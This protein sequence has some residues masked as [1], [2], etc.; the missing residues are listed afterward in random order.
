M[1]W[2][3][4]PP[5]VFCQRANHFLNVDPTEFNTRPDVPEPHS[6]MRQG[7]DSKAL[8][9]QLR[10]SRFLPSLNID[11]IHSSLIMRIGLVVESGM[12]WSMHTYARTRS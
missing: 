3:K 7:K 4:F 12:V 5:L 6:Q 10:I 9:D 2:A 11:C 1:E 8:H